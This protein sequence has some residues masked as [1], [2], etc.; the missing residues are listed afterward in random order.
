MEYGFSYWDFFH[1]YEYKH[2]HGSNNKI[3]EKLL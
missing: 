1:E 2:K 3:D